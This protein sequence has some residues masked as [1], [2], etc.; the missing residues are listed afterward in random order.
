[1]ETTLIYENLSFN[2]PSDMACEA[3]STLAR[4]NVH[5]SHTYKIYLQFTLQMEQGQIQNF[6]TQIPITYSHQNE[7][8]RCFSHDSHVIILLSP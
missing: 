4:K 8:Q 5:K 2:L 7:G 6:L 3:E 1:M